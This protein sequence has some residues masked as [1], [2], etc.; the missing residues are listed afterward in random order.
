VSTTF[1]RA[2]A[3]GKITA[4]MFNLLVDEWAITARFRRDLSSQAAVAASAWT[5]LTGYDSTPIARTGFTES[6]G[7]FTASVAGLYLLEGSAEVAVAGAAFFANV[8]ATLNGTTTVACL[9]PTSPSNGT[10]FPAPAMS[11]LVQ[12]AAGDTIRFQV[13]QETGASRTIQLITFSAILLKTV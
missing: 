8:R 3:A 7:V 9:G 11:N 2:T 12:L 4:A 1:T 5:T 13:K 10:T 6:S